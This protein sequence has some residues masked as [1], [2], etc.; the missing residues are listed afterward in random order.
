MDTYYLIS[1]LGILA[2]LYALCSLCKARYYEPPK[3]FLFPWIG[4][5]LL[6]L[7]NLITYDRIFQ[8]H[9]FL[10]LTAGICCFVLGAVGYRVTHMATAL[11]ERTPVLY[12]FSPLIVKIL[13]IGA[14]VYSLFELTGMAQ[15]LQSGGFS[16][17]TLEGLRA[18]HWERYAQ[19]TGPFLERIPKSVGRA[20]AMLLAAGAPIFWFSRRPGLLGS[21]IFLLILLVGE[22]LLEAGRAI[23]ASVFLTLGYTWLLVKPESRQ[24][25]GAAFRY[26][27]KPS[28][29]SL[30]LGVLLGVCMVYYLFI[31]F[32]QTRNRNL[33]GNLNQYLGFKHK[34]KISEWV[35]EA[36]QTP[37]LEWLPY[38]AHATAYGS[39]PIVKYTF[40]TD[41]VEVQNWHYGGLY[42]LRP[43]AKVQQGFTGQDPWKSIRRRIAVGSQSH[44]YN[45]NPWATG[46][47]DLVIDFDSFGM[48]LVLLGLGFLF[49][50]LYQKAIR[51]H[52]AEWMMLASQIALA[53]FTFA[54]IS[55]L[56]PGL[57]NSNL[58]LIGFL[59]LLKQFVPP[60]KR[61]I[62]S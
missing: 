57:I 9:S 31:Y 48:M 55:P 1:F 23:T 22:D 18:A 60:P 32:P 58:L 54:F 19:T 21:S 5:S 36:S 50:F 35:M 52:S 41:V 47:R 26:I 14:L 49:Q 30:A 44:G 28:R 15:F 62:P 11:P 33:V 29:R 37:G 20:C 17:H 42:N 12:Y 6:L 38:L 39:M 25:A 61:R 24:A 53:C 45:P 59:I 2:G 8:L 40:F 56:M 13:L 46:I 4:S 34:A 16:R 51:S 10:T 3:I 7:A 27:K 43:L